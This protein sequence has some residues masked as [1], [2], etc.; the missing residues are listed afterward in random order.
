MVEQNE[1]AV[2]ITIHFVPEKSSDNIFMSFSRG[3]LLHVNVILTTRNECFLLTGGAHG[4]L[5][6]LILITMPNSNA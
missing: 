4:S 6:A 3:T 1:T 2:T 5:G